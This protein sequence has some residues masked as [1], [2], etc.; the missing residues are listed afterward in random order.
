MGKK[1]PVSLVDLIP[2]Y[3]IGDG[4]AVA[5]DGS[6]TVGFRVTLP[7]L[8]NLNASDFVLKDT[9]SK[10]MNLN[11]VLQTAIK[12]LPD[13]YSYHQQD[14]QFYEPVNLPVT[15]DYLSRATYRQYNETD[16]L[17]AVTYIFIS[18]RAL[19]SAGQIDINKE[20]IRDFEDTVKRFQIGINILLPERMNNEDWIFYLESFFAR[21]FSKESDTAKQIFDLSFKNYRFGDMVLA[22]Y[23]VTGDKNLT[24]IF[25]MIENRERSSK[26]STKYARFNSFVHPVSWKIPCYK[27]LNNIIVKV[28][29]KT[30]KGNIREFSNLVRF[31]MLKEAAR[32][33]DNFIRYM[34]ENEV[35]PV[36][37]H[38]NAFYIYPEKDQNTIEH[39]VLTGFEDM[40]RL[41]PNKLTI[42]IDDVFLGTVG[43]CAS[44]LEYPYTLYPSFL[45]EAIVFSNFEG[46]YAQQRNGIIFSDTLKN[47]VIVDVDFEPF[48]LKQITNNNTLVVGPS[49]TGK[50]V[51]MNYLTASQ[52]IAGYFVFII[53]IGNSYRGLCKLVNGKFVE[54][55]R[56][57]KNLQSNPFLVPLIDPDNDPG[58]YLKAEIEVIISLIFVAWDSEENLNIKNSETTQVLE[59]LLKDFYK[60]RFLEKQEFICF[61]D[62]YNYVENRKKEG[63]INMGF[64]PVDSF[65]LVMKKY[66]K[67][68]SYGYLF[69]G[70]E[71][72]LD[73]EKYSLVV[74]EL[75]KIEGNKVLFKLV[76]SILMVLAK[77]VLERSK[78][79]MKKF[80]LDECWRFLLLPFFGEFIM[81]QFKTIRKKGAGIEIIVQEV[82]DI[83]KT[84][85]AS[86]ILTNSDTLMLLSH[87]GKETGIIKHKEL[88]SLTDDE[89]SKI[90]SIKKSAHEIYIRLGTYSKIYGV[91]LSPEHYALFTTTGKERD[92]V[93]HLIEKNG[94]DIPSS[95]DQI[96]A[97]GGISKI[98]NQ[99]MN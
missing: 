7:E 85:Y 54:M 18:R 47:P 23:A 56:E 73:F 69:N 25:P 41:R 1:K 4:Y 82:D 13:G 38:F 68:G 42:D 59:D 64:F 76:L 91:N 52:L 5:K 8:D 55:D 67:S 24:D 26:I 97:S 79:P 83:L 43:G 57:G 98:I 3:K 92:Y 63:K 95:I 49:G 9:N 29:E 78:A 30:V 99:N 14:I 62:F 88:L 34:E 16:I 71:N 21:D 94:G 17:S 36:Y 10:G 46:T 35:V 11:P 2:L 51:S 28:P 72:L 15:G 89:M 66:R 74:F 48:R 45:H 61:E 19:I 53:D 77:R 27:I 22:G 90:L 20:I 87:E 32:G 65:L 50:S 6:L 93:H 12:F 58:G 44:S 40:G 84:Q 33:A 37:H 96:V 39:K 86:T 70:T 80:R 81:Y 60:K 75:E 31:S